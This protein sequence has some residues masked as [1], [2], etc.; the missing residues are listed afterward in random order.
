MS[1]MQIKSLPKKCLTLSGASTGAYLD[2]LNNTEE[3]LEDT[4]LSE[5]EEE[6]GEDEEEEEE[7]GQEEASP[8]RPHSVTRQAGGR[9]GTTRIYLCN[10]KCLYIVLKVSISSF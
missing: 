7:P 3:E 4:D 1:N 2:D 9:I 5:V 6:E 10:L 8:P